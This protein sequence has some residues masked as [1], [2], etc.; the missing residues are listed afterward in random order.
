[1]I[2]ALNIKETED[3]LIT[4]ALVKA[5]YRMNET[6]KLLG[7]SS[8]TLYRKLLKR[9]KGEFVMDSEK[10][11]E[12]VGLYFWDGSKYILRKDHEGWRQLKIRMR[13]RKQVEFNEL[14]RLGKV[15][16]ETIMVRIVNTSMT[17]K[18]Y[19]AIPLSSELAEMQTKE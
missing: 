7:I 19:N 18:E 5:N 17:E 8:R 13:E 12:V 14:H 1:M 10:K 11:I 9:R 2:S 3:K 15:K 6:A 16:P 4:I